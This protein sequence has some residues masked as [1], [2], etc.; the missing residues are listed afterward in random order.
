MAA[1]D[2]KVREPLLQLT[3]LWRGLGIAPTAT[4]L[5]L[6]ELAPL[7]QTPLSASSVFNF[8]MPDYQSPGTIANLGLY[9][10]E[11]QIL[12]E[13]QVMGSASVI[14]DW[15]LGASANYNLSMELAYVQ[16]S[17]NKATGHLNLQFMGNQMSGTMQQVIANTMFNGTGL[18]SNYSNSDRQTRVL[19]A[20]Y[21][22][23]TSPE[24]QTER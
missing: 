20:V 10:P 11:L 22:I 14:D 21:L 16:A 13:K 24:L 17:A 8:F 9:S 7:G 15:T 4:R 18:G 6:A 1:S 2:G 19:G 23:L 12:D 5:R 3:A